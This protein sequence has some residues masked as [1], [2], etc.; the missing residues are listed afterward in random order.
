VFP[1][2]PCSGI[3]LLEVSLVIAIIGILS[4]LAVPPLL[5]FEQS[6]AIHAAAGI[7]RSELHRA[8]IQSVMRNID[9]RVRVTSEVT[10]LTE[11]QTP[12]WIPVAFHTMPEGFTISA[13]NSPEFHPHGHVGPMATISVWNRDG[14]RA[15][16]IVSRSGR[17]RTE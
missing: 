4:V 17:V 12:T 1:H 3:S 13:N 16:I 15:K 2:P 7:V 8:R 11:C 10:F 5:E 14:E 6:L 9:C